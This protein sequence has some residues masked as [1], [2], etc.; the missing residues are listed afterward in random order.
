MFPYFIRE[1]H[2]KRKKQVEKWRKTQPF[3]VVGFDS[4]LSRTKKGQMG[5]FKSLGLMMQIVL[6]VET[7]MFSF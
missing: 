4:P 5:K 1:P 6:T 2:L 7:N 3:W